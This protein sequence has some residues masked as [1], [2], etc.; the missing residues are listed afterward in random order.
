MNIDSR[1]KQY[2]N[3]VKIV[4]KVY[5][6]IQDSKKLVILVNKIDILFNLKDL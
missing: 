2:H 3:L 4:I 1:N 5:P 6:P